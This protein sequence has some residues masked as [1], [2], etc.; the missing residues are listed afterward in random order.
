MCFFTFVGKNVVNLNFFKKNAKK[1]VPK[2]KNN[3]KKNMS[4]VYLQC[5]VISPR[6][7]LKKSFI[8]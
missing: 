7:L 6:N 5:S 1:N 8:N 2:N 3:D 4:G